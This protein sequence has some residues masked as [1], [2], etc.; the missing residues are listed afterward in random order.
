MNKE[1]LELLESGGEFLYDELVYLYVKYIEY[2][3]LVNVLNDKKI[4]CI[5]KHSKVEEIVALELFN[6]FND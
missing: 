4:L 2:I 6:N 5:D 3:K 1:E